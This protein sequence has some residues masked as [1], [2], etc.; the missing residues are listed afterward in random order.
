M[1]IF[2]LFVLLTAYPMVFSLNAFDSSSKAYEK[3]TCADSRELLTTAYGTVYETVSEHPAVSEFAL[4]VAALGLV[5][6]TNQQR[7]EMKHKK[8][9]GGQTADNQDLYALMEER[10]SNPDSK[11]FIK[12]LRKEDAARGKKNQNACLIL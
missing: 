12:K 8:S 1:K 2:Y 4:L 3:A 6:Y 7:L 9:S 10:A 11:A 5:A